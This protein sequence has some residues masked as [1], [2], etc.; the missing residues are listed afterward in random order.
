MFLLKNLYFSSFYGKSFRSFKS[1]FDPYL[2]TCLFWA[3]HIIINSVDLTNL[4]SKPCVC[5]LKSLTSNVV[6]S[7]FLEVFTNVLNQGGSRLLNVNALR[8][9]DYIIK[10]K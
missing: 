8:H 6:L 9:A 1:V 4:L 5:E 2:S 3:P 10:M 7:L